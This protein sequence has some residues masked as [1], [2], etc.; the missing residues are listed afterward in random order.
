MPDIHHAILI[1][2]TPDKVYD[3]L[4]TQKGLAS[5]WS[6]KAFASPVQGSVARFP[7]GGEYFKEMRIEE[8]KPGEFV[9]WTCITGADEWVGTSIS[10][11]LVSG[12]KDEL[13]KTHPEIQDQLRQ[14]RE[15]DIVTLLSFHHDKWK[16]DSPMFAECNFTWGMFLWSLK[17]Y[18]ETVTGRPCPGQ[19]RSE[20]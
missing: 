14:S 4:T 17:L 3:A 12:R 16:K 20:E 1:A 10:F 15:A 8:L 5:W 18:C 6:P 2:S 9:S 7:F 19:H 13:L 11:R